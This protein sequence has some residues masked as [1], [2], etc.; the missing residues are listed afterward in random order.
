MEGNYH[1]CRMSRKHK[2]RHKD[3]V[4]YICDSCG[5]I[6]KI[7]IGTIEYWDAKDPL[8]MLEGPPAFECPKC[9]GVMG[10]KPGEM[11]YRVRYF[12]SSH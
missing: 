9:G 1:L 2:R 11:E 6:E 3:S 8:G 12:F 10:Q 4:T 7:S 5:H